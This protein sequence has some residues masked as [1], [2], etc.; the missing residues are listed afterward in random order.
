MENKK[1]IRQ[2]RGTP[3]YLRTVNL[4]APVVPKTGG[5]A[6]LRGDGECLKLQVLPPIWRLSFHTRK[7]CPVRHPPEFIAEIA[8]Q[9]LI[10]YMRLVNT[11]F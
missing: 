7:T 2:E 6:P 3:N 1:R 5:S 9:Q 11:K 8:Q 4:I 10:D